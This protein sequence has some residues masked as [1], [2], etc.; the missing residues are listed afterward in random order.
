MDEIHE[1]IAIT[2][3]YGLWHPQEGVVTGHYHTT[4]PQK[5]QKL[6]QLRQGV[7]KVVKNNTLSP[8]LVRKYT[9]ADLIIGY[10]VAE[11]VRHYYRLWPGTE[12]RGQ[13]AII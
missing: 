2:E 1:V 13:R 4:E 8:N 3:K 10:G 7:I 6:G 5:I 11:V 12:L 9:V